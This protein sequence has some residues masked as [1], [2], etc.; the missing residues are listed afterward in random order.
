MPTQIG[1]HQA[2]VVSD[3]TEPGV[4]YESELTIV[5]EA[6][7]GG[8]WIGQY[9]SALGRVQPGDESVPELGAGREIG[10]PEPVDTAAFR[11]V[12]D[13]VDLSG[14]WTWVGASEV[15]EDAGN[16]GRRT[17]HHYVVE[18]R[19]RVTPV[20]VRIHTQLDG[21]AFLIRWLEVANLSDRSMAINAVDCWSGLVWRVHNYVQL[22]PEQ[23]GSVFKVGYYA[24]SMWGYEG[25][26]AWEP[27]ASG[28]RRIE[29]R[30]GRSGWGRPAVIVGNEAQGEFLSVELAW[31]GNWGISLSCRQDV[32]FHADRRYGGLPEARLGVAVGPVGADQ[33]VRV[34][35][36]RETV[37]TPAVHIAR[38]HGDLD[39]CVQ[40]LHEHAREAVLAPQVPEREQRFIYNAGVYRND[41][42]NEAD[43]K[44]HVDIAAE[45]GAELLIIDAG[46]YGR[47]PGLWH[48]NVGDWTEGPWL[49]NGLLP[50]REYVREKGLLF[51]LWMEPE[52]IGPNSDL[53]TAHPDWVLT[54]D[55][56][57][58]GIRDQIVGRALDLSKPEV[59]EWVEGQIGD[60]IQR[61]DLDLFR[62]DYNTVAFEGGNRVMDGMVENTLWR[63]CE[64]LF[65]IFDRMRI[66]FPKV[67]FENCAGG[68]GRTDL[69]IM[70]RFHT[71]WISDWMRAPRAVQILN[72]M[73]LT[74]PPEVCSRAFALVGGPTASAGD[75][76]TQLRVPLFG[77]PCYSRTAPLWSAANPV[78]TE[79]IMHHIRLYKDFIRPMLSTCRVFHHTPVLPMADYNGW[80]V[81]EYAARDA[82]R[83]YVGLFRLN[84]V[85]S[86]VFEFRPRGLSAAKRYR[87]TREN[88]GSVVERTGDDLARNGLPVRLERP[89]TSELVLIEAA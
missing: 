16:V 31:S 36:A 42:W 39:A 67:V 53:L 46:W 64:V 61:Y 17:G 74:L 43:L 28:D 11:L 41:W 22:V 88:D 69:G 1:L 13:D 23:A 50:V 65:G 18:L 56:K 51:G 35:A 37:D 60:L 15:R 73:S 7:V 79:L 66:R 5:D 34:L 63:H 8:H 54:R 12:I 30:I 59:A 25:D 29:G 55:G 72:G 75:L 52:S 38:F 10:A 14:G 3:A 81:L 45:H 84:P 27:V 87:I 77:H 57:P 40:A 26:F 6:L 19:H 89:L 47:E 86:S 48:D 78:A 70:A 2:F 33:A 71:T 32:R 62:L 24:S 49:S 21:S 82:S 44:R 76:Q 4:H 83:A 68:G 20:Q 58:F 85:G 9:W 80:C